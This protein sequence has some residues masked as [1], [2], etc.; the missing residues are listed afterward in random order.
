[1]DEQIETDLTKPEMEIK[2]TSE[3]L[4]LLKQKLS[5]DDLLSDK[6]GFGRHQYLAIL[7]MCNFNFLVISFLMSKFI[8]K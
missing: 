4:S 3:K 7:L 5:F 6:I 2:V 8:N 1:M